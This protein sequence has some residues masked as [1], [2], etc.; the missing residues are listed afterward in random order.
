MIEIGPGGKAPAISASSRPGT[1][2]VPVRW[3]SAGT[4]TRTDDS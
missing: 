1:R 4:V 3:M 2:T